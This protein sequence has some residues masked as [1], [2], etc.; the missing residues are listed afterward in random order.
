MLCFNKDY[1]KFYDLLYKNK[2]YSKEFLFIK[3]IL[4][5]YLRKPK[6]LMDL[7]CGTGEYSKLMT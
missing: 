1:S 4:K 3:K 7:G 5:K 2:N 6:T